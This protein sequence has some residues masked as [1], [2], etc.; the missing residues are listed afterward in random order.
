MTLGDTIYAVIDSATGK[1]LGDGA[2][3]SLS[4]VPPDAADVAEIAERRGCKAVVVECRL[5]RTS[6]SMP[7]ADM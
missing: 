1:V 5:V 2:C 6:Q 3:L 7:A 4:S